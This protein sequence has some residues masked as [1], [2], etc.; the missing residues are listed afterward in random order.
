MKADPREGGTVDEALVVRAQAGDAHA[1][2]V[3]ASSAIDRLYA[4]AY[5]ILR[6]TELAR[7]ATQGALLEAWRAI[8]SL[9][10]PP[11][12]E[13][14]TY[15]LVVHACY[16]QRRSHRMTCSTPC[17]RSF[18]PIGRGVGGSSDGAGGLPCSPLRELA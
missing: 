13:A 2:A 11:R 4:I 15:G 18:P 16:N 12:W 5:R 10:D 8:P 9:R 17:W 7:A 6:D 1:F 14:W 3:L